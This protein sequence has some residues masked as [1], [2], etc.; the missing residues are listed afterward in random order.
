RLNGF[1]NSL[2]ASVQIARSEAVKRNSGVTLC[3]SSNGTSCAA[4][5]GWEQGWI[6]LSGTT[7]L[8]RQQALP[9][10]FKMTQSGGT[11]PLSFP[12]TVLGATAATL[13][14]CRFPPVGGQERVIT[15][16]GTGNAYVTITTA[17]ACS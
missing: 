5:G 8:Q 7:V 10:D 9:S 14:F 17:G 2:R 11:G 6:V 1:A 15:I 3:A 4:S 16:S 13:T 12:S